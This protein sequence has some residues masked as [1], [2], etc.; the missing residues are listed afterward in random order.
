MSFLDPAAISYWCS[1]PN[2]SAT[3]LQGWALEPGFAFQMCFSGKSMEWYHHYFPCVAS[4]ANCMKE[5]KSSP[6]H[7]GEQGVG[8]HWEYLSGD[9]TATLPAKIFVRCQKQPYSVLLS[10]KSDIF[11]ARN[12][13]PKSNPTIT[14]V[15]SFMKKSVSVNLRE[16]NY[17][18]NCLCL[19]GFRLSWWE[20]LVVDSR[21]LRTCQIYQAITNHRR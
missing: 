2:I 3:I 9:T 13:W 19:G 4:L 20:E 16:M 10:S 14:F 6:Q 18:K 1:L 12:W 17:V 11:W 5:I 15:L 7:R 8:G 21:S